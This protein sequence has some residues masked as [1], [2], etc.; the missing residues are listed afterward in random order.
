MV[1]EEASVTSKGQVTIPKKI[2]ERLGLEEGS[3]VS[4]VLKDGEAVILPSSDDPLGDLREIRSEVSFTSEEV[5][6]MIS[7]SREAWER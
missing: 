5:E 7:E 1:T 3:K 2:R 4:F 6:E